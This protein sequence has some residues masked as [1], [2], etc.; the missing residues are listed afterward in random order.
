[1]LT[2]DRPVVSEAEVAGRPGTSRSTA[3]RYLRSLV[4]D[5]PAPEF[6]PAQPSAVRAPRVEL[7][8]MQGRRPRWPW[9]VDRDGRDRRTEGRRRRRR[10]DRRSAAPRHDRADLERR[11]DRAGTA[12]PRAERIAVHPRGRC[13]GV[14][15]HARSSPHDPPLMSFW[16][17]GTA[18]PR[19][20]H[21]CS[22]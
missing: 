14:R 2:D 15:P 6:C 8:A 22:P 20:P 18:T 10:A 12:A 13:Q 17:S 16:R 4:A 5:D 19:K 3:Y 11:T 21:A 7:P 1:M 9:T